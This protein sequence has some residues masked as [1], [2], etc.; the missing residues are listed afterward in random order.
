MAK[1]RARASSRTRTQRFLLR[2][3]WVLPVGAIAIGGGLLFLTYAF[4]SIPLPRDIELVSSAE[5]YDANGRLIGTFSGEVRRFLID[6]QEL[7]KDKP[8][9]GEAVV[10]AEDRDF[11]EHGGL[12]IR[13]IVR[14]AWAN[15]TGGEITQGGSTITQQYVKNAVL[16]DPSRTVTRKVQEAILAVK[17]ERRFSKK[18][19]LSFYLNTIYLGRGAYGIEAAA[20]TYFDKHADELTLSEAAFFAG[21]IPAPESYQPDENKRGAIE[22]RDR[23]LDLMV[24]A[25]YVSPGRAASATRQRLRLAKA[26]EIRTR[27]QDAAYFMEWLRKKYL[28]PEFGNEL[29]TRGLKIHTTLNLDMQDYAEEAV[30]S[31]LPNPEDPEA[32]LVSVTPRGAVRAFVGGRHFDNLR[33]ARGFN[34]AGDFPGRHPGSA[35]KPFTLLT[36]IEENISPQSHF[37]GHSPMTIPDPECYTDGA[38]WEVDNYAN[39]SYGTLSLVEGTTNSVNTVFAQLIA[40]V[41]PDKVA[42]NLEDFSFAPKN[43]E[44]EI[45]GNCSLALGAYDVTPLEMARAFSGFAARGSLPEIMPIRYITDSDGDCIKAYRPVDIECDDREGLASPRVADQN[46]VDVL[47]QVLTNV[48]SGGTAEAADIGRPV[49]GKTGTTQDNRDAWFAG[50]VPQLTTV[51]WMGYPVNKKGDETPLMQYC[52]DPQLCKPVHGIEVTGGSFPAQIWAAYMSRAVANMAVEDF[53][54]P[55]DLP[56]EIVNSPAPTPAPVPPP[57]E[58]ESPAPSP[59]PSPSPPPS[60]TVEPSPSPEPSIVPTPTGGGREGDP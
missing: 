34:F 37:S 28:Y 32:S 9:I 50:Y 7:L 8:F 23:V 55:E 54:E 21:I 25:G 26:T 24:D 6:T 29:Y 30:G 40:E 4:A 59:K 19:I 47:T 22:R 20:R 10:A 13:G 38:P 53:P 1:T 15:V 35:F 36:A 39:A 31:I 2:Y 18:E 45:E 58:E 44:D 17:M 42:E 48:V 27:R 33:K 3:G 51:V 12:S 46:D 5:V 16:H 11:Y 41:G 49:A 60:P 52:A 43:G 56:D 14:A 57:A